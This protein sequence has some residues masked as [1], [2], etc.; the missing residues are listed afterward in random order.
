MGIFNKLKIFF[1]KKPKKSN[2]IV[3]SKD[4]S[5]NELND[6]SFSLNSQ[7]KKFDDVKEK[8]NTLKINSN[9][10]EINK[11]IDKYIMY[12]FQNDVKNA[13][14]KLNYALTLFNELDE[15]KFDLK[16]KIKIFDKF[17]NYDY[18]FQSPQL[19]KK[20]HEFFMAT[21]IEELMDKDKDIKKLFV[22][23]FDNLKIDFEKIWEDQ[24]NED[25]SICFDFLD[26]EIDFRLLTKNDYNYKKM[27]TTKP[28]ENICYLDA[29]WKMTKDLISIIKKSIKEKKS[30]K[31]RINEENMVA[32]LFGEYYIVSKLLEGKS[33]CNLTNVSK[34][35]EIYEPRYLNYI[36]KICD[37]FSEEKYN[38]NKLNSSVDASIFKVHWKRLENQKYS[39]YDLYIDYPSYDDEGNPNGTKSKFLEIKS[40]HN[41]YNHFS[42]EEFD[43][44]ISKNKDFFYWYDIFSLSRNQVKNLI[45]NNNYSLLRVY[46]VQYNYEEL[47]E[48]NEI[49]E[50]YLDN[51][52]NKKNIIYKCDESEKN[53]IVVMK[54]NRYYLL[55]QIFESLKVV[56]LEKIKEKGKNF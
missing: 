54:I 43:D 11:K 9:P 24:Q 14:E 56:D 28:N 38:E 8:Q 22:P 21:V 30:K 50:D 12:N 44:Y 39:D 1:N 34:C 36:D 35:D 19:T 16:E 6:N 7:E 17:L 37:H 27:C 52:E 45:E 33:K 31:I 13:I 32:G 53:K 20:F 10:E 46:G 25:M 55:K 18:S 48:N 2:E 15:D 26:K 41:Y 51:N 40:T 29:A 49:S 4:F 42:K 47:S 23:I 3:N 5:S